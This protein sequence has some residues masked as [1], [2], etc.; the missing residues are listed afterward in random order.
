[1]RNLYRILKEN[2]EVL[3]AYERGEN[4]DGIEVCEVELDVDEDEDVR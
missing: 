4:I 2:L 3:I 1:M